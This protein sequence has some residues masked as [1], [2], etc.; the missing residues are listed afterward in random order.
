LF[1]PKGTPRAIVER[2]NAEVDRAMREEAILKRMAA[3][4]A[5]QPPPEQ[6]TP[7]ALRVL[8]RSDIAKWVPLVR[9]AG[10]V[11]E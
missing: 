8:V 9:T 4:G 11:G 6:C 3:L 7:Q 10:A 2:I 1:L 5:D